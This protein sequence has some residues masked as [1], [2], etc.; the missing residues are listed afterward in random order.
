[1]DLSCFLDSTT[2]FVIFVLTALGI[3]WAYVT[4][5]GKQEQ[6]NLTTL[7][8]PPSGGPKASS[9]KKANKGKAKKQVTIPSAIIYCVCKIRV[10]CLILFCLR[11]C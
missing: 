1:M 10:H 8:E 3:L 2:L 4:I 9:G 11:K 7:Y 5:G 6:P